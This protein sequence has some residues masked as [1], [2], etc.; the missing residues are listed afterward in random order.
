MSWWVIEDKALL[1]MLREVHEGADP[2]IVF[3]EHYANSDHHYR[4]EE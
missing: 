1:G 2:D 3:T 4:E